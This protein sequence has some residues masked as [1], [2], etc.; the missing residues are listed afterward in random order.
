MSTAIL[1][2]GQGSQFVGMGSE[3]AASNDS[4]RS[5]YLEADHI[6]PGLSE[7][8]FQ[9]P[10]ELLNE[11]SHTQPAVYATEMALWQ[12][13]RERWSEKLSDI[14]CMAGHSLGEYSALTAAGSLTFTD[15]LTVVVARGQAMRDAG[16]HAP[17]GM[18]VV[19]GLDDAAA[20]AVTEDIR[21]GGARVWAANYNSPGQVVLAGTREAL[22]L[23]QKAALAR[24]AKRCVP[25]AVSV[26]CHTPLM[27]EAG[28]KLA[29]TLNAISVT[30]PW[31]PVVANVDAEPLSAPAL[32]RSALLRQLTS[33]V[34]WSDSVVTM[35]Q[36][37][38][39]NL[40][41]IGPKPVLTGLVQRIDRS[42]H[43]Q[44][45]SDMATVGALT[46]E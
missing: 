26:A 45:V 11:T 39:T 17:G 19:L 30:A 28:E 38:V 6:L 2:T 40:V 46:W 21:A 9:G 25:L 7:L 35:K 22:E 16:A 15:G 20:E 18:L 42:L 43:I 37:G 4:A 34:R 36:L 10:E 44:S 12:V 27:E 31:V 33:P 29:I 5:V 13:F 14:V 8:C 3:L 32:I 41:E 24:G 1:F 23:A